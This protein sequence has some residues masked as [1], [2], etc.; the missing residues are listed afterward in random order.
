MFISESVK[1]FF[2]VVKDVFQPL[3]DGS[4]P[5]ADLLEYSL[6][7]DHVLDQ[8]IL[9]DINLQTLK[10]ILTQRGRMS[11]LKVSQISVS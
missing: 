2:L 7:N 1:V 11:H 9:Q 5:V 8:G 10:G 3:V 4:A 6:Q